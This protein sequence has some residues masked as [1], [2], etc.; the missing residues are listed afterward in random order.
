M[1]MQGRVTVYDFR[2]QEALADVKV[3]VQGTSRNSDPWHWSTHALAGSPASQN[4][5]GKEVA[6]AVL[7]HSLLMKPGRTRGWRDGED[8]GETLG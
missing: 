5:S 8:L 2:D 4:W 7:L 1:E 3:T 6:A